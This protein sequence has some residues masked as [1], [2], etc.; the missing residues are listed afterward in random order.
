MS[1]KWYFNFI[2]C[3]ITIQNFNNNWIK[4]T[5]N[6]LIMVLMRL[7]NSSNLNLK[8][9]MVM[10]STTQS[11]F[12]YSKCFFF[13]LLISLRVFVLIIIIWNR[14]TFH[15]IHLNQIRYESVL[16]LLKISTFH[17]NEKLDTD[18]WILIIYHT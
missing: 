11:S 18:E 3:M 16:C 17:I 8:S 9:V 7:E 15:W 4:H 1:I 13:L 2:F 6:W 5:I 14:K 10:L 12:R